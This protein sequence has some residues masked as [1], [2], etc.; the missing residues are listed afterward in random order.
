[1]KKV[2][3]KMHFLNS[4][5]TCDKKKWM[6]IDLKRTFFNKM[7]ENEA[8]I[9]ISWLTLIKHNPYNKNKIK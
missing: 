9:C 7:N 8:C 6:D 1:M 2:A 4:I 3:T 5:F